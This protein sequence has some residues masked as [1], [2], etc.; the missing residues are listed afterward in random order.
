MTYKSVVSEHKKV[1]DFYTRNADVFIYPGKLKSA[2]YAFTEL[3]EA[4]DARMRAENSSDLRRTDKQID[5]HEEIG[6]CMVMLMAALGLTDDDFQTSMRSIRTLLGRQH[7]DEIDLIN[8]TL[9]PFEIRVDVD[10]TI[11]ECGIS[12]SSAMGCD[13]DYSKFANCIVNAIAQWDWTTY[14]MDYSLAKLER[15]CADKRAMAPKVMEMV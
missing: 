3:A 7:T 11:S 6:D 8:R 14:R 15:R 10:R 12:I 4:V 13:E 9:L 2:K 5:Y 1:V